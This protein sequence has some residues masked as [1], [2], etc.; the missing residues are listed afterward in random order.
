MSE[1]GTFLP[2]TSSESPGTERGLQAKRQEGTSYQ[3]GQ[4][5]VVRA[6]GD[7]KHIHREP[8][9][10]NGLQGP[11]K[12]QSSGLEPKARAR[13]AKEFAKRNHCFPKECEGE[14]QKWEIREKV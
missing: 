4:C 13:R 11:W 7:P 10:K 9:R 5:L 8:S 6:H 1:V 2:L 14:S 12:S 3:N